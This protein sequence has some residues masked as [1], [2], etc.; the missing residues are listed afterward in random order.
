[1]HLLYLQT[2]FYSP[3]TPP[4]SKTRD[5]EVSGSRRPDLPKSSKNLSETL[6]KRSG[7]MS[8]IDCLQQLPS[9]ERSR[10][11]GRP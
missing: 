9:L 4:I 8:P 5:S 2:P 3:S 1:M 11:R 10:N 6:G 7:L